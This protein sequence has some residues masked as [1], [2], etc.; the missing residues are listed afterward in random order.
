MAHGYCPARPLGRVQ[1]LLYKDLS[2][3][4]RDALATQEKD[5][6]FNDGLRQTIQVRGELALPSRRTQKPTP[7]ALLSWLREVKNNDTFTGNP[8]G[9]FYDG[10]CSLDV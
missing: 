5:A 3:N 7:A 2:Y 1:H 8:G 6:V 9:Q 10:S 4:P